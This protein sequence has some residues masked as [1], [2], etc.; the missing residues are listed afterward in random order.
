MNVGSKVRPGR[1][2][3]RNALH[4]A[5]VIPVM[6][7]FLAVG[8]P[9]GQ[10]STEQPRVSITARP[11]APK[12]GSPARSN[13]R[14][15]VRM[16]LVPVTV[17]D[18]R[19]RPVMDLPV[20]AFHLYEGNVEQ[21]IVSLFREEGPISVGFVFDA[22]SSMK[23]RMDRSMAAIDQFLKGGSEGDEF[24]LIRFS[25]RVN[26][27]QGFTSDPDAI[28]SGLSMVQPDGWTSLFDAIYLGVQQMK[29]AKHSRKALFILSDGAD[30]NSRYTESEVANRI[31]ESDVR[32][33]AV[34]LFERFRFLEK[35][36]LESGGKS[37]LARKMKDLPE[38]VERL[39]NELRNQYVLGY[40]PSNPD[41][42]GKY[43][44]VRVAV[45]PP[46]PLKFLNVGWR[47]GYYP[48]SD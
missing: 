25:D 26:L 7:G 27:V 37:Y 17:S 14:V 22:S 10:Y 5:A 24:F 34:G 30:N 4:M 38:A 41:K 19:A 2:W 39:S 28:L 18:Q 9:A 12:R 11:A 35:L 3:G 32:V 20:E 43:R 48:P 1:I 47:H 8:F 15:D 13:L 29:S 40:Y 16:V 21:K 42:D 46:P 44:K 36:A 33:Y 6:A 31:R 23:K 45:T